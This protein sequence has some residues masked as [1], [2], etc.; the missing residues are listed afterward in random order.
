M[1]VLLLKKIKAYQ[2]VGRVSATGAIVR[3]HCDS[4]DPPAVGQMCH[5]TNCIFDSQSKLVKCRVCQTA[6]DDTDTDG[7]HGQIG[8]V[9]DG[10]S[11]AAAPLPAVSK[12]RARVHF[13]IDLPLP[14][15]TELP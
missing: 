8:A 13:D 9:G 12:K 10:A 6:S 4:Y 3:F 5:V 1:H 2:F 15:S 11:A 7:E 14:E